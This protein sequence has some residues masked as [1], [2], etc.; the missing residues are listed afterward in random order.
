MS[1]FD[2]CVAFTLDEEGSFV[3]NPSDPGGATNFGITVNTLS[4]WRGK[5]CSPADVEALTADEAEAIYRGAYWNAVRAGSLA[6]GVDLMVFDEAVNA[7]PHQS[8]LL[9]QEAM[10]FQGPDLDGVIGPHTAASAAAWDPT[11]LINKL[12]EAQ[13]DF[14]ERLPGYDS[15]GEGWMERLDRRTDL[16]IEMA[17][18]AKPHAHA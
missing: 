15:F 2:D 6:H 12:A 3:D 18:A 14:Y 7:G 17:A 9:L 11:R 5:V 8:A 4:H 1:Q 13:G 16:A 10:G